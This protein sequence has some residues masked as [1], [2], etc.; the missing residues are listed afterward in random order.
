M[1]EQFVK[2]VLAYF[3]KVAPMNA[4]IQSIP[5]GV[6]YPCY[7]VNKCDIHSHPINSYY[8]MNTIT[9]YVRCFGK[10]EVDLRNTVNNLTQQIFND[11]RAIPILNQDGTESERYIR[12]EDIESIEIPTDVNEVYCVELNFSF[13]TQFNVNVDELALIGNVELNYDAN[14]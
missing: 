4:Y 6:K 9:L 3:V 8:F 12:V 7:L 2:S 5:L 10:D 13:D 1:L 14:N 11:Y